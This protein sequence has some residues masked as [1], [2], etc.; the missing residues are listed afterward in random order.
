MVEKFGDGG[1]RV[2]A[3]V[4]HGL[5]QATP[6]NLFPH[7]V[8]DHLGEA[9]VFGG[10]EPF[11]VEA[12]LVTVIDPLEGFP[13]DGGWGDQVLGFGVLVL[14]VVGKGKLSRSVL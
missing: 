7:P 9:G 8:C 10:G 1:F 6:E 13:E 14:V 12:D 2:V 3:P 11:P 4:V 5:D